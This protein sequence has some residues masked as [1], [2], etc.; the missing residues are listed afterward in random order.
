MTTRRESSAR[1]SEKSGRAIPPVPGSIGDGRL[2]ERARRGDR[3]ALRTLVETHYDR[4]FRVACALV[5]DREAVEDLT[6]ETFTVALKAI[7]RFRGE[8]GIFTWLVGIL[9]RQWLKR[10]QQDAR[11]RRAARIQV[12]AVSPPVG[13]P[14]ETDELMR[15]A[16]RRLGADDR[17]ILELFHFEEL[18]YA[19]IARAL[20]IPEGTV[21][22]R[23][24]SARQ[25]L[26][27][28]LEGL[29]AV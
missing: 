12:E 1:E 16:F 4:L 2:V 23:L 25:K 20:D 22:S 29:Y 18:S 27:G 11:F 10:Q 5:H 7:A 19:E 13:A 14:G 24:F 28:L 15:R 6:Q 17:L 3:S 26:R 8:S 9:K 21:K